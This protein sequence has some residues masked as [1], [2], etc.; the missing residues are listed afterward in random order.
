MKVNI[1]S[2]NKTLKLCLIVFIICFIG[3]FS[4]LLCQSYEYYSSYDKEDLLE[5]FSMKDTIAYYFEQALFWSVRQ[6][7]IYVPLLII[8]SETKI[9]S[10]WKVIISLIVTFIGSVIF[11][12]LSI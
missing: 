11:I 12:F 3:M 10:F 1:K 2:N 7:I 8:L 4:L 6:M 5:F 9:K